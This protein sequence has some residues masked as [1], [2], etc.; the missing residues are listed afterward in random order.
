M[1]VCGCIP[2]AV[3]LEASS[4]AI[5][6]NV[7]SFQPLC[8][9][10]YTHHAASDSVHP[11]TLTV[12][13]D[14]G[15]RRA[16]VPIPQ[17]ACN[18]SPPSSHFFN[19]TGTAHEVQRVCAKE[20]KPIETNE[21]VVGWDWSSSSLETSP[22]RRHKPLGTISIAWILVHQGILFTLAL[23]ST[24]YSNKTTGNPEVNITMCML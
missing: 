24:W 23:L 2:E 12:I 4:G 10:K 6:A 15:E 3:V 18:L 9:Y 1:D 7:A 19:V 21:G 13:N 5:L 16:R 8:T 14:S 11:N 20:E 17:A 22:P